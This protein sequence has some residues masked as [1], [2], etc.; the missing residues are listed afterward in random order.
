MHIQSTPDTVWHSYAKV[1]SGVVYGIITKRVNGV[2]VLTLKQVFTDRKQAKKA[3]DFECQ[4]LAKE[5]S[6]VTL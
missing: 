2:A 6:H 5:I 1:R 3:S 4:R